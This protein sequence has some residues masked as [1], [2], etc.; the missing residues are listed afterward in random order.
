MKL[1]SHNILAILQKES[2]D[3]KGLD[4]MELMSL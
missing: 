2:L 3:T 1:L 4:K